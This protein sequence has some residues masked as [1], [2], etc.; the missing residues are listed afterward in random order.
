[1]SI[2]RQAFLRGGPLTAG[3][4]LPVARTAQAAQAATAHDLVNREVLSTSDC[5][6]VRSDDSGTAAHLWRLS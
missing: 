4:A 2:P 1:M 5:R 3:G 6:T